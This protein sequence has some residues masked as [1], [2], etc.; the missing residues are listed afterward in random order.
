MTGRRRA[1]R[2]GNPAASE[3]PLLGAPVDA[4]VGPHMVDVQTAPPYR[5]AVY[6]LS[7]KY[8]AC[9]AASFQLSPFLT[10]TCK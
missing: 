3:A 5:R 8:V 2:G 1:K 7:G 4:L 9:R 10:Q 6:F